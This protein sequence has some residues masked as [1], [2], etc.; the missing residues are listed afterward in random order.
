MSKTSQIIVSTIRSLLLIVLFAVFVTRSS[1]RARHQVLIVIS[2]PL[3]I[4]IASS[5]E[6]HVKKKEYFFKSFFADFFLLNGV[7]LNLCAA[8]L[9]KNISSLLRN[10]FF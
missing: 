2:V 3:N 6:T 9:S 5:N 7:V 8:K 4:V 1:C 10:L